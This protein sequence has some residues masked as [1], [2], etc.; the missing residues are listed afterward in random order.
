M[1]FRFHLSQTIP[2]KILKRNF[3]L[4]PV[5]GDNADLFGVHF[6]YAFLGLCEEQL[7]QVIHDDVNFGGVEEG[8]AV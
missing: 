1:D 3:H 5:G 8:G 6:S 2:F 4:F 7:L